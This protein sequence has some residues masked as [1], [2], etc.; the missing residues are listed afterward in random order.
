[1]KNRL[2]VST[3]GKSDTGLVRENNE[4]NFLIIDEAR[5]VGEAGEVGEALDPERFALLAAV[6]DGM[7]GHAA[8]EVASRMA[9]ES[10]KELFLNRQGRGD[11]A[12]TPS[13]P[14]TPER[15]AR[16]LA[17][18]IEQSHQRI[19]SLSQENPD[20]EGMGA[21]LS[22]LLIFDTKAA[23]AH[24]GDSRIYRLRENELSQ[25]TVDHTQAQALVEMGRL[26]PERA[27]QHPGRHLLTQALG[28]EDGIEE[29]FTHVEDVSPGDVFLLCSDG[30]YDMVE[31][32]SI[33][34]VLADEPDPQTACERLVALALEAGGKDNV[35]AVVVKS[36]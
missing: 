17:D 31:D 19:L 32:D 9:C 5:E 30:L 18:A 1:M 35:T 27:K 28:V 4:D 14:S 33:K 13:T 10:L 2:T 26:K 22:A 29:V 15:L 20:C 34:R 7:G 23:I 12:E 24:V 6:S 8:G 3:G 25:L 36:E 16:Q 21:T 11:P